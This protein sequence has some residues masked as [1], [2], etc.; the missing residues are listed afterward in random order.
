MCFL[1]F[2]SSFWIDLSYFKSHLALFA[3]QLTVVSTQIHHCCQP[4]FVVSSLLSFHVSGFSSAYFLYLSGSLQ[5]PETNF[6]YI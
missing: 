1:L 4:P 2:L 6:N 3:H 5:T